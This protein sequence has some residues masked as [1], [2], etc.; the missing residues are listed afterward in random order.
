MIIGDT[1]AVIAQPQDDAA[2]CGVKPIDGSDIG[3]NALEPRE[4]NCSPAPAEDDE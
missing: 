1:K 2:D 3:A 4:Q